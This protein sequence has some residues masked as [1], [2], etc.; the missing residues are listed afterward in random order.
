MALAVCEAAEAH[1]PTTVVARGDG[2]ALA[3]VCTGGGYWLMVTARPEAE[4]WTR[5]DLQ[6][7]AETDR[8]A[9]GLLWGDTAQDNE[10][11]WY[12]VE[13]VPGTWSIPNGRTHTRTLLVL[14]A[15]EDLH[16][17]L[18]LPGD[19]RSDPGRHVDLS[20]LTVARMWVNAIQC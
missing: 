19:D 4:P 6:A 13:G 5:E 10:R 1:D 20:Q 18:W 17:K 9:Q 8:I 12:G 11:L 3:S 15:R 7:S 14:R 2:V 16:L